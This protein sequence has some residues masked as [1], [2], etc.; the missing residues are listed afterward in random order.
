MLS[1]MR[2]LKGAPTAIAPL[3]ALSALTPAAAVS[4]AVC[5]AGIAATALNLAVPTT[6]FKLQSGH[7][8]AADE[9]GRSCA[10]SA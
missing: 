4:A 6:R 1:A 2:V 3:I 10:L 7:Q 8:T 9:D 5:C